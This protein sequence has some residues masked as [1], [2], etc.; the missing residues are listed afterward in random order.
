MDLFIILRQLRLILL[1]F[2]SG[3]STIVY[4]L[5]GIALLLPFFLNKKKKGEK[6]YVLSDILR[7]PSM[8]LD[9]SKIR[10]QLGGVFSIAVIV[11]LFQGINLLLG[12]A[13]APLWLFRGLDYLHFAIIFII[14]FYFMGL[15]AKMFAVEIIHGEP[16]G[17]KD[18]HTYGKKKRKSLIWAPFVF[19]LIILFLGLSNL[20]IGLIGRIPYAGQILTSFLIIPIFF[21]S[22]LIL[23]VILATILGLPLVPAIIAVEDGDILDGLEK[24][25][26]LLKSK[27]LKF[28]SYL[29]T[30]FVFVFLIIVI[31]GY[32]LQGIGIIT[33]RSIGLGMTSVKAQ[34]SFGRMLM[35]WPPHQIFTKLFWIPRISE[36]QDWA[37]GIA[38][39]IGGISLY[40]I[41]FS[42]IAYILS[43][44]SGSLTML[45]LILD[46][47]KDDFYY[48][49]PY[50]H[51]P[52]TNIDKEEIPKEEEEEKEKT[53][54]SDEKE[55]DRLKS[56]DNEK[57]EK[58]TETKTVD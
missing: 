55:V 4:T 8:A 25:F 28:I 58:D 42:I 13:N 10:V 15:L 21:I 39:I 7:I 38:G 57:T 16:L 49:P 14:L 26:G 11:W 30:T 17:V 22:F 19:V 46:K 53:S 24:A 50:E 29:F 51:N 32:V 40:A 3:H 35:V 18:A 20:A 56:Q 9:L 12:K 34:H 45:Y 6:G 52:I 43:V 37:Y 5:I 48:E 31:V 41:I 54:S 33:L 23:F 2:I 47:D 44:F 27:P 36:G 1:G